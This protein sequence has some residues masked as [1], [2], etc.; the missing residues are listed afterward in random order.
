[1]RGLL[2]TL[3]SSHYLSGCFFLMITV[4]RLFP[5]FVKYSGCIS[6]INPSIKRTP[7]FFF[8]APDSS[9]PSASPSNMVDGICSTPDNAWRWTIESDPFPL[10][11]FL[12]KSTLRS[13]EPAM[14][15]RSSNLYLEITHLKRAFELFEPITNIFAAFLFAMAVSFLGWLEVFIKDHLKYSRCKITQKAVS[16]NLSLPSDP[17]TTIPSFA[18]EYFIHY[19]GG[20]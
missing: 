11:I 9:D 2:E 1:M 16:V 18:E 19:F 20:F 15:R 8:L 13:S 4:L 6:L 7:S 3:Y 14:T 10:N 5:F 17:F 12:M